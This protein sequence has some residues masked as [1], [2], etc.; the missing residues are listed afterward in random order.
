MVWRRVRHGMF[1]SDGESGGVCGG[2]SID[3]MPRGGSFGLFIGDTA[4]LLCR[5]FFRL[6]KSPRMR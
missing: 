6:R 2:G 3:G 4:G 1:C 5:L